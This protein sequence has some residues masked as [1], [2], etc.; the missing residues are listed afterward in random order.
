MS[1]FNTES[2]KN[3]TTNYEG[4]VAYLPSIRKELV[5][6]VL[7]SMVSDQFYR[8]ENEAISDLSRIVI[9]MLLVDDMKFVAKTALYARDVMGVR[10]ISHL[11]AFAIGTMVKGEQ[12]TKN[13]FKEIVI[14]PDDMTEIIALFNNSNKPIPN[15]VKKGFAKAFD[16]FS[17]YQLAKYRCKS[18]S[19]SLVDVVN[20]VHPKPI[21]KNA[22]ALTNLIKGKLVST[23]TWESILTQIGQD[24][25]LSV[26]QK[27]EKRANVWKDLLTEGKLGYL[28]M[29]RNIRNML[30][31]APTI[32]PLL[33]ESLVNEGKIKNSRI[34]PLHLLKAFQNTD[35]PVIRKALEKAADISCD[36]IKPLDGKVVVCLDKS[37]SMASANLIEKASLFAFSIAKKMKADI[38][39]Y[40]SYAKLYRGNLNT[41]GILESAINVRA[42][43]GTSLSNAFELMKSKKIKADYLIILS[44]EQPWQGMPTRRAMQDYCTSMNITPKII[45]INMAGYPTV[46]FPEENVALIAGFSANIYDIINLVI[47]DKDALINTIDKI[48]L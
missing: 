1:K 39:L 44:D 40:D 7:T 9:D 34:F 25:T 15:S 30:E 13:F 45:S 23:D 33:A 43:G 27:F 37:G 6:H 47:Q 12:W 11:L 22:D 16:K 24:D 41:E 28:A 21:E 17:A 10:S 19:V 42:R 26:M 18:K 14:R 46:Q 29:L 2:K 4:G 31:D 38:I 48:P 35:N 8:S 36:N 5:A 20:L 32:E 3:V